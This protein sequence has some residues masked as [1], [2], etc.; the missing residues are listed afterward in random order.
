MTKKPLWGKTDTSVRRQT[1]GDTSVKI[2][3]R[4][5]CVEKREGQWCVEK[6][7]ESGG[8]AEATTKNGVAGLRSRYLS[9]ICL[10]HNC[11]ASDLPIDLLP[12]ALPHAFKCKI[13]TTQNR[14]K[15]KKDKKR[16]PVLVS[17]SQTHLCGA[18]RRSLGTSRIG[19]SSLTPI[20]G[21]GV[22]GVCPLRSQS[23]EAPQRGTSSPVFS[24]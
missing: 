6:R 5:C 24:D 4:Q 8:A 7:E 13:Y 1:P 20:L 2:W 19:S 3:R 21:W 12:R 9:Q 15:E 23:A 10:R 22:F 17:Q 11:K 18:Q 14:P 16:Q